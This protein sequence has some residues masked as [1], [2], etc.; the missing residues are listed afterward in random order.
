MYLRGYKK[1]SSNQMVIAFFMTDTFYSCVRLKT[2]HFSQIISV[3]RPDVIFHIARL[4]ILWNYP[5]QLF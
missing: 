5:Q 1:S 3:K 2:S 4:I